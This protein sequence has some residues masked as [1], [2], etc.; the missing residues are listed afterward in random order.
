MERY[1]EVN[2]KTSETG[3]GNKTHTA[4]YI[5]SEETVFR[6][7]RIFQR[8]RTEVL[9]EKNSAGREVGRSY[10]QEFGADC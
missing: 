10:V 7:K 6:N 4:G 9:R 1:V 5:F 8:K 2:G 3:T